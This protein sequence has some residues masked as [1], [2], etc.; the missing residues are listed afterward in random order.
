M[1]PPHPASYPGLP[2]LWLSGLDLYHKKPTGDSNSAA[3]YTGRCRYVSNNPETLD[4][5]SQRRMNALFG[6]CLLRRSLFYS[7]AMFVRGWILVPSLLPEPRIAAIIRS[8]FQ[9][10]CHPRHCNP[11]E[12]NGLLLLPEL[13]K[14]Q[15][16]CYCPMPEE[17]ILR[18]KI[19]TQHSLSPPS[20][21]ISII[22]N[23][24]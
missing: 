9:R 18:T 24:Y 17:I 22:F 15:F 7:Q 11:K 6:V 13:R 1:A 21:A 14:R 8:S 10:R 3:C 12:T 4:T 19:K 5:A 16:V 23:F 20:P 2:M